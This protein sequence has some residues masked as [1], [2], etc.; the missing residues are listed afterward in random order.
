MG[1]SDKFAHDRLTAEQRDRL[2]ALPVQLRSRPAVLAFHARPDH[3]ERYLAETHR[4]GRLVRAPLAA[5]ARRLKPLDPGCRIVLCGHSHRA[6][7]MRCRT[8][9]S[10]FNPGSVGCPA[11]D[12]PTRAGACVRAGLAACALWHR[13]ARRGWRS[14]RFEAIA[15]G[16]D[17]EAAARRAEESGRPEWAHAL[18]T[19][20]IRVLTSGG[21]GMAV[22]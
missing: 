8:G 14:G 11:Y 19:G 7:L 16:Y 22:P 9:R 4:R 3:D 5:I 10:I 21:D 6:E 18:R 2:A 1:P 12:D 17:H 13:R 15:V 20:F